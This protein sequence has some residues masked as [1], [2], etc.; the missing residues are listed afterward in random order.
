M[1]LHQTQNCLVCVYLLVAN[2]DGLTANLRWT[3]TSAT[4]YIT[5][6][7]HHVVRVSLARQLFAALLLVHLLNQNIHV[8][9][10][11]LQVLS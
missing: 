7:G 6:V 8:V 10:H 2:S 9:R 5:P 3:F 1:F 4:R 11:T